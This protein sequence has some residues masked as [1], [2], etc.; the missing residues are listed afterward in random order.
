[1]YFSMGILGGQGQ[2]D[3]LRW[4]EMEEERF[5]NYLTQTDRA[6]AKF[7][8]NEWR[9]FE[10]MI[11][12]LPD[13]TPKPKRIPQK[14]PVDLIKTDTKQYEDRIVNEIP[15]SELKPRHVVEKYPVKKIDR[16]GQKLSLLFF[17]T[18][19]DIFYDQKVRLNIRHLDEQEFSRVW[20]ELSSTNFEDM[21][22]Q[23]YDYRN[24]MNL[25]DW[26]YV[27][28]LNEVGNSLYQNN[29]TNERVL[30]V[31]FY[32]LRSGY[33]T[34][35]GYNCNNIYLLISTN[36][37]LYGTSYYSLGHQNRRYYVC[38]IVNVNE[39]IGSLYSYEGEYP[40]SNNNVQFTLE[41]SPTLSK[42]NINKALSFTYQHKEYDLPVELNRNIVA[43]Y[44]MFPQM[45]LDIYFK[46]PMASSS[47]LSIRNGLTPII[48]G[49]S[50]EEAVNIILRFV[51]TGFEYATDHE[52]F[53]TENFLFPDET[54]FYD[55]SDCEDRSILFAYL[56]KEMIGLDVI[57]LDYP[58]HIATA[59]KFNSKILGDTVSFQGNRYTICDPTY[60]NADIG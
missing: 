48:K 60:I 54:L 7:L 36:E 23:F 59:V 50:K 32:L 9:K 43:F 28:F 24:S 42:D 26:G 27:L 39:V 8:E 13:T 3:L 53:Q 16:T 51:Q 5:E 30:F 15:C 14:E 35:L 55:Q 52:Q 17:Q 29:G 44:N 56:V 21:L 12:S 47:G 19:M 38:P 58:G 10:L 49:I 6:F 57:G 37:Q 2:D 22:S 34:R 45:E 25:N 41:A 1:M 4:M 11:E 18:P 33:D 20:K 46:A 31:W 40:G